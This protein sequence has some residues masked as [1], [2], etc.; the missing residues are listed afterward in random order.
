MQ[1]SLLASSWPTYNSLYRKTEELSLFVWKH[2]VTWIWIFYSAAGVK[3]V[4]KILR[5]ASVLTLAAVAAAGWTF[6]LAA[7]RKDNGAGNDSSNYCDK[8]DINRS[9]CYIC[10]RDH[11][12]APV[13]S[14][15]MILNRK[16]TIHARM[17]CQRTT[18]AAHF[19]PSSRL[20]DAIAA[21][22]GV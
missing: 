4:T 10:K 16:Q 7:D 18:A 1:L 9:P 17:H 14:N 12:S 6:L 8:N 21:T 15:T 3:S 13:Q 11:I 5:R 2:P 22:Q 20:I 19:Q